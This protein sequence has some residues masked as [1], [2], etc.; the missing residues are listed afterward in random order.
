MGLARAG[1]R[2]GDPA[3]WLAAGYLLVMLA[4]GLTRASFIAF[5]NAFIGTLLIGLAL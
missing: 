1:T 4:D 2:R 5:P 3:G